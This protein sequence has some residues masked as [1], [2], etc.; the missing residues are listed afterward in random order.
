MDSRQLVIRKLYCKY[1]K[2]AIYVFTAHNTLPKVKTFFCSG[3]KAKKEE[4]EFLVED[5]NW[6]DFCFNKIVNE[7]DFNFI[8]QLSRKR[9]L[10]HFPKKNEVDIELRNYDFYMKEGWL[11]E[12]KKKLKRYISN[13]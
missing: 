11:N 9:L 13:Q 12:M 2:E 5:C 4:H 1:M 10:E 6:A 3:Y 7:I 8:S